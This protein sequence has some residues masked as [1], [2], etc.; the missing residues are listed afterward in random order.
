M[1]ILCHQFLMNVGFLKIHFF[2]MMN[3]NSAEATVALKSFLST[4]LVFTLVSYTNVI[5]EITKGL[6]YLIIYG[7]CLLIQLI[8]CKVAYKDPYGF[9][10]TMLL[11][12]ILF[13]YNFFV[14]C[15]KSNDF[16]SNLHFRSI[17]SYCCSFTYSNIWSIYVYYVI[18]S[19]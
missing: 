5:F 9:Q 1:Y 19:F 14:D 13:K 17:Y 2:S 3:L 10:V 18:V 8:Y 12:F 11:I 15:N 16:G 7:V 4:V 6:S